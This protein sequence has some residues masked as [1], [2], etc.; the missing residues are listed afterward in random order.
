MGTRD[1]KYLS[2]A[3]INVDTTFRGYDYSD[4]K[5]VYTGKV[6]RNV[7]IVR[8]DIT[9]PFIEKLIDGGRD[10]ADFGTYRELLVNAFTGRIADV[11]VISR[12]FKV[13]FDDSANFRD[14]C[15][16]L[17]FIRSEYGSYTLLDAFRQE[18]DTYFENNRNKF[19]DFCGNNGYKIVDFS[20]GYAYVAV[21]YEVF[22][23]VSM[24]EYTMEVVSHVESRTFNYE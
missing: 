11:E 19:L 2:G 15:R 13:A 8:A 22:D 24:E 3:F 16:D 10:R 6:T 7:F 14:F 4:I 23:I 18:F 21:P 5:E 12:I 17:C 9:T 20:E 1:L